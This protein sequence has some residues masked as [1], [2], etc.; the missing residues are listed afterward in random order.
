MGNGGLCNAI[1]PKYKETLDL[2]SPMVD[3]DYEKGLFWAAD[4]F[5]SRVYK[6]GEVRQNITL[7][8]CAIHNEL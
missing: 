2:F 6:F 3:E 4:H 7:F 5:E 8:I 1:P